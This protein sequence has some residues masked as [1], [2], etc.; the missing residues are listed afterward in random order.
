MVA[1]GVEKEEEEEYHLQNALHSTQSGVAHHTTFIPT[2]D[3]SRIINN[4]NDFYNK[5]FHQ[6]KSLIR[7][8]IPMEEAIGCLY[9]MDEQD[10]IFFAEYTKELNEGKIKEEAKINEDQFEEV[11]YALENLTNQ[12]F[13]DD[14]STLEELQEYMNTQLHPPP[15]A[16]YHYIYEYWKKRRLQRNKK[17]IQPYLKTEELKIDSDPYVCFR[18]RE[19]K[20]LR[21]TRRCDALSLEKLKRLQV[22]MEQAHELM[23]MV[24]KREKLRRDSLLL[25]H[26]I[27]EQQMLIRQMKKKLGVVSSEKIQSDMENNT[28]L[29]SISENSAYNKSS[30]V[31]ANSSVSANIPGAQTNVVTTNNLTSG[32]TRARKKMRKSNLHHHNGDEPSS[33]HL[34]LPKIKIRQSSALHNDYNEGGRISADKTT[35]VE[36]NSRNAKKTEEEK[37]GWIDIMDLPDPTEDLPFIHQGNTFYQSDLPMIIDYKTFSLRSNQSLPFARRRIGRGGRIIFDR[38]VSLQKIREIKKLHRQSIGLLGQPGSY[39]GRFRNH[40]K[41]K[42]K[43]PW[44]KNAYPQRRESVDYQW[45]DECSDL[46]DFESEEEI[47]ENINSLAYNASIYNETDQMILQVKPAFPD[48]FNPFTAVKQPIINPNANIS[49]AN[50]TLSSLSSTLQNTTV[51]TAPSSVATL[52][53]S[54]SSISNLPN[55]NN[56]SPSSSLSNTNASTVVQQPSSTQN[57]LSNK[58]ISVPSVPSVTKPLSKVT[59]TTTIPPRSSTP[60]LKGTTVSSTTSPAAVT[61]V[62]TPSTTAN[63]TLTLFTNSNISP[64]SKI[65]GITSTPPNPALTLPTSGI[66]ISSSILQSGSSNRSHMS[67]PVMKAGSP[68]NTANM[69]VNGISVNALKSSTLSNSRF[70]PNMNTQASPASVSIK[71][72]SNGLAANTLQS[73]TLNNT[74]IDSTINN[75]N[76]VAIANAATNN[77]NLTN[78]MSNS[79]TMASPK[80]VPTINN[81]NQAALNN[82]LKNN[83]KSMNVSAINNVNSMNVL[84]KMKIAQGY[85]TSPVNE[86]NITVESVKNSTY[87]S[88]SQVQSQIKNPR[89]S[90]PYDAAAKTAGINPYITNI[91]TN[92]LANAK[93]NNYYNNSTAAAVAAAKVGSTFTFPS[94]TVTNTSTA[95]TAIGMSS[96]TTTAA[97]LVQTPTLAASLQSTAISTTITTTP[98]MKPNTINPLTGVN[99][100]VTSEIKLGTSPI[101]T[102]NSVKSTARKTIRKDTPTMNATTT[103][104][105]AQTTPKSKPAIDDPKVFALRQLMHNQAQ[106]N[107]QLQQLTQQS[108]LASEAATS[109]LHT[110]NV[111]GASGNVTAAAV[112]PSAVGV[113]GN[114]NTA[115]TTLNGINTAAHVNHT[116]SINISNLPTNAT[117]LNAASAIAAQSSPMISTANAH[118]PQNIQNVLL[119]SQQS[120]IIHEGNMN[121]FANAGLSPQKNLSNIAL[122]NNLATQRQQ[123]QNK[124]LMTAANQGVVGLNQASLLQNQAIQNPL[125]QQQQQRLMQLRIQQQL[126][127]VVPNTMNTLTQQQALLYRQQQQQQLLNALQRQNINKMNAMPMMMGNP[128]A[129][130]KGVGVTTNTSPPRQF[131]QPAFIPQYSQASQQRNLMLMQQQLKMIN[132]KQ[133]AEQI[134]NGLGNNAALMMTNGL[135]NGLGGIPASTANQIL[136]NQQRATL[137]NSKE[138]LAKASVLNGIIDDKTG[139]NVLLNE[140]AASQAAI[141]KKI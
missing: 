26:K 127:N 50:N 77:K 5:P 108:V 81:M 121:V 71:T 11:M 3:A 99:A 70:T 23:E 40:S 91:N 120:N 133:F 17:P 84:N 48:Q 10:E 109:H 47:R 52:T 2:P 114:A 37:A 79:K 128:N 78:V 132:N 100:A 6:P 65:N 69:N 19:I 68:L 85:A 96:K 35:Q 119:N 134:N 138:E 136:I 59:S 76:K 72:V 57:T 7:H 105:S 139:A 31:N 13:G 38:R 97:T 74:A 95:P 66:E 22:E 83:I 25:E 102:P 80:V 58:N 64:I 16:S 118:L 56:L 9:N 39:E 55:K 101:S 15:S 12:K 75:I 126:R 111:A 67:T 88:Q 24:C 41:T 44:L 18:R 103:L 62:N 122:V 27:F 98:S 123:Q 49:N 1:T 4:Y 106:K 51:T 135:F 30:N 14:L 141:S 73:N 87:L 34:T 93:L 20:T 54:T 92:A 116:N 130:P 124:I 137:I 117:E 86:A 107:A 129:L 53:T 115:A 104:K 46:D 125:T 43:L 21:K 33:K 63:A 94:T 131:V 140:A 61:M 60:P 90:S 113:L 32:H 82:S 42:P 36:V 45:F 28:V 89:I 8:S 29:S 112:N 110:I